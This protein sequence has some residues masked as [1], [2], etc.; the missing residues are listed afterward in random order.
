MRFAASLLLALG[1]AQPALASR[2]LEGLVVNSFIQRCLTPMMAGEQ[3][4]V[5]GLT[6]PEGSPEIGKPGGEARFSNVD[7]PMALR[8]QMLPK[9]L[10]SCAMSLDLPE[11]FNAAQV[12]GVLTDQLARAHFKPLPACDDAVIQNMLGFEGPATA[13]GRRLGVLSFTIV[14]GDL[15]PDQLSLIAAESDQPLIP[16]TNCAN[17]SG[18]PQ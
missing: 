16:D 9:G 5:A 10:M 15:L 12:N 3:P 13:E 4:A 6:A 2:N 1:L 11:G 7:G 18:E 14:V 17:P 8:V